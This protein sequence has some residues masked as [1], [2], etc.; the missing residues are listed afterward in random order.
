MPPAFLISLFP[1][2][3]IITFFF[4][5]TGL[6]QMNKKRQCRTFPYKTKKRSEGNGLL[7]SPVPNKA[8]ITVQIAIFHSRQSLGKGKNKRFGLLLAAN[9]D[10]GLV[11]NG[12]PLFLPTFKKRSRTWHK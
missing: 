4:A 6:R 12:K 5:D 1:V 11:H 9:A 8:Q 10:P 7:I 2:S 3:L